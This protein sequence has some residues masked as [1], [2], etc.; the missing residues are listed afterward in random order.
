MEKEG[1]NKRAARPEYFFA[2]A[3]LFLIYG[4]LLTVLFS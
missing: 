3:V 4:V 2:V 1:K